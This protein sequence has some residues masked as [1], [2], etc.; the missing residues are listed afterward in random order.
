MSFS[1]ILPAGVFEG[2]RGARGKGGLFAK[3]PLFPFPKLLQGRC[4]ASL[5]RKATSVPSVPRAASQNCFLAA[6]RRSV[7]RRR[8][9]RE[10]HCPL[11]VFVGGPS[12]WVRSGGESFP[13]ILPA[14][15]FEGER[16]ARRER[17]DFLQKVPPFPPQTYGL[18]LRRRRAGLGA[19][20]ASC[21][22]SG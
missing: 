19:G 11:H 2:E 17:G 4:K 6:G 21:S 12:D 5:P 20:F 7:P 22:H 3:S 8:G 9:A 10:K 13:V 1:V 18:A 16:G 15:V 14:G